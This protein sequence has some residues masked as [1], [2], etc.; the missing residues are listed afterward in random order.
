MN[1]LCLYGS[2]IANRGFAGQILNTAA[3]NSHYQTFKPV[4]AERKILCWTPDTCAVPVYR[5]SKKQQNMT[6]KTHIYIH[7]K[8]RYQ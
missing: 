5:P 6:T 4:F 3:C 1:D 8:S 7:A 2:K